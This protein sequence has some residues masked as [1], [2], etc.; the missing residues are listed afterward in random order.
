MPKTKTEHKVKPEEQRCA[1][2]K[3]FE[4]NSCIPLHILV[5]MAKAYNRHFKKNAIKL[6]QDVEI[7]NPRKYK[8]YLVKQFERD[9]I[10]GKVC[11]DQLC[12][13]LEG[14]EFIEQ[15][16]K[17]EQKE[18]L[19][20]TF[21]P[22]GPEGKFDWLSTHNI[23]NVMEQYETKF[24]NFKYLGAVPIDFDDLP[25]Y[26]IKNLNLDNLLKK[27]KS[28]LGLIFNLDEHDKSGSHWVALYADIL[29]GGIYFFDSYGT[30]PEKRIR[31]FMRRLNNY[32][33]K[34]LKKH[35]PVIRANTIQHQHG[36][37]ACGVYSLNFIIQMLEGKSFN[38]IINQKTPDK[39]M[40]IHRKIYFT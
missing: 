7:L 36:D 17:K 16:K 1:P 8:E 6:Y 23:D 9:D 4:N 29:K 25:Q 10:L 12:W 24:P 3:I 14:R 32:C 5:E 40:N 33:V 35:H 18:L 27:G 19:K 37:N 20:Q 15:M 38:D 31:K 26:G 22:K 30:T 39:E 28:Q 11:N 2:D 34:K 21:R 13:V